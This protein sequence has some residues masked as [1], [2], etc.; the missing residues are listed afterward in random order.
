MSTIATELLLELAER[1]A[2][3][4]VLVLGGEADL[5]NALADAAF[6]PTDIRE[7]DAAAGAVLTH[8]EHVSFA[9]VLLPA[10]P[11][12]DLLRRMLLIAGGALVTGGRLILCGA[13]AEGGKSAI[14]DAE[15]LLG[16]PD[17]AGYQAKHRL[18]IFR[19]GVLLTPD[20]SHQPGV[21]PGTWQNF[22]I[23]T[24]VGELPLQTQ[25]GVFAGAKLDSGTRLLL[26]HLQIPTGAEVLDL[27]CGV[28]VIGLTAARMGTGSI[29][30]TDSNLLAVEAAHRN[31]E[32]L[33]IAANVM[34]SDVFAHLGDQRFDLILSN[35][36]FHRGKSVDLTVAN[37]LIAEAPAHLRP[38]GTLL[39][40]ANAFLNYD[41]VMHDHFATVETVA[42]TPQ[43]HM[44]RATL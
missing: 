26:D 6:L 40:V 16:T 2:A 18:A 36:P 38:G 42:S 43:F 5:A 10:P 20:W 17:W 12:R 21:A 41:K 30:M 31:A 34:A 44:I 25:A 33:G 39:V 4:P 37:R 3:A 23:D 14:K 32:R 19:K 13:N 15:S 8:P 1:F 28:G 24:P 27:G 9:T 22:T 29:T 35:P 11:D 7:L